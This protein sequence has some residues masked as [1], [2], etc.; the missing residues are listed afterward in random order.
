[1][2][3]TESGRKIEPAKAPLV[4]GETARSTGGERGPAT[5]P[6]EP[7]PFIEGLVSRGI[8]ATRGLELF[9]QAGGAIRTQSWFAA[10]AEAR[11]RL[12]GSLIESPDTEESASGDR[13][14][15]YHTDGHLDGVLASL[16]RQV[17]RGLISP[18]EFERYRDVVFEL[19]SGPAPAPA[20]TARTI[21]Q[22]AALEPAFHRDPL[23]APVVDRRR[24][25]WT[26]PRFDGWIRRVIPGPVLLRAAGSNSR[27][28]IGRRLGEFRRAAFAVSLIILLSGGRATASREQ[29]ATW[30]RIRLARAFGWMSARALDAQSSLRRRALAMT[31]IIAASERRTASRQ[32]WLVAWVWTQLFRALARLSSRVRLARNS[33]G[34]LALCA[35]TKALALAAVIGRELARIGRSCP[36]AFALLLSVSISRAARAL[37]V[38]ASL[39]WLV[40]EK[41]GPW[42]V[43]LIVALAV[44]VAP[45]TLSW[46]QRRTVALSFGVLAASIQY[47][48]WRIGVVNLSEWWISIPLVAAETLGALHVLGLQYTIWPRREAQVVYRRNPFAIPLY[49]LIP[50]V[51]EGVEILQPTVTGAIAAAERYEAL[52]PEARVTIIVCNDGLVAGAPTTEDV[53]HMCDRLGVHCVTRSVSG[54]A[55]AGNIENARDVFDVH[56]E[57]FFTIFDADQIAE[58]DFFLR[59]VPSLADPSVAWVQTAQHYRNLDEPVA[60]WANDQQALFYRLICP[61]KSAQNSAFICGTNFV[62]RADALDEIGGLPQDSVTEDFAASIRLHGRWRGVYIEGIFAQGL[63][64]VDL[65]SYFRQQNRWARGTLSVLKEPGRI[66]GRSSLTLDQ[67]IQYALSCTHYLSGVRDVIY[68]IAPV[69]FLILG[70]PAVKGATL[71]GFLSHFLTYF[72]ASQVAFWHSATRRTTWRGIVMGFA[73]FPTLLAATTSVALGRRRGFVLTPKKRAARSI[74]PALPHLLVVGLVGAALLVGLWHHSD[75]RAVVSLVW[76]LYTLLMLT[77]FLSLALRDTS[78]VFARGVNALSRW[79][80]STPVRWLLRP[81]F[82]ALIAVVVAVGATL[83]RIYPATASTIPF[84][85]HLCAAGRVPLGIHASGAELERAEALLGRP[86]ILGAT[87]ELASGFPHAWAEHV[88]ARGATPWLTLV[89][90]RDGRRT[91]ESSLRSIANG[92]HDESLSRWARDARDFGHPLLLTILPA[93][94]RNWSASSAITSGG[95]PQD[96]TPAWS[97]IRGLFRGAPNVAFVWAP[98]DPIRDRAYA[99]PPRAINVVQATWFRYPGTRWPDPKRTLAAITRR[100][101]DKPI[102]IDASA[103]GSRKRK[104]AWLIDVVRAAAQ[105]DAVV[106]YHEGGPFL[107]RAGR[108]R[109]DWSLT[110]LTTADARSIGRAARARAAPCLSRGPR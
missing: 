88:R 1:M 87:V 109:R 81:E 60:R 7:L 100:H 21:V 64:P 29:L 30:V 13:R 106:V 19:A 4:P 52:Y 94:D 76:L 67:R 23:A 70:T 66:F 40:W 55:K 32:K 38:A 45:G 59:T 101:P 73:S 6:K 72:V 54:G 97:R 53:E 65:G 48:T 61:G 18:K 3:T 41:P 63:G 31:P 25:H 71:G 42:E 78:K 49:V 57:V 77:A 15:L 80:T 107:T 22:R 44:V 103:V 95:I 24:D 108:G 10:Y 104:R 16:D 102:L 17:E 98:A 28:A 69:S 82:A 99:P 47:F 75:S 43:A 35:A 27:R 92:L 34:A 62:A 84:S 50:T 90:T 56:G 9:R 96:V 105:R 74:V 83:P 79:A 39:V 33:L 85:G 2:T 11:S 26:T 93:V 51:D 5:G 89:F 14:R 46:A 110:T 12:Q 68:V 36:H 91:L 20:R 58:P 86:S 8:G 37:A